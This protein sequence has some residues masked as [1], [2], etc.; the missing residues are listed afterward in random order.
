M[1]EELKR[2]HAEAWLNIA[3]AMLIDANAEIS[4]KFAIEILQGIRDSFKEDLEQEIQGLTEWGLGYIEC[5]KDTLSGLE[6][7]IEELK[8]GLD[9]LQIKNEENGRHE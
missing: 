6:A 9:S 7:K 3:K 1:T 8:K 4:I 2:K 5:S